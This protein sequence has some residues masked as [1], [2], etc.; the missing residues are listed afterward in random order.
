MLD[1][2]ART[3]RIQVV[4]VVLMVLVLLVVLAI[5]VAVDAAKQEG[6]SS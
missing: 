1:T 6:A 4:L 5:L 3:V 2:D